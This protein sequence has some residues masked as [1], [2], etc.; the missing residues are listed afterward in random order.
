MGWIQGQ[1]DAQNPDE[2][3]EELQEKNMPFNNNWGLR[4]VH[5]GL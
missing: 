2:T 5:N 3:V 1:R 4:F